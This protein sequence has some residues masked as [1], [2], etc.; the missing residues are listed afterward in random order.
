M[1]EDKKEDPFEAL[2]APRSRAF[3]VHLNGDLVAVY[4]EGKP[5]VR[6][7]TQDLG[8]IF[9]AVNLLNGIIGAELSMEEIT[10]LRDVLLEITGS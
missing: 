5:I 10:R 3:N 4:T 1:F 9:S 6:V 7:D 8:A 2:S